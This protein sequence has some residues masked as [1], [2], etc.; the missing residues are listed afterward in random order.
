[1]PTAQFQSVS[2]IRRAVLREWSALSPQQR[3]SIR[4]FLLQF[5]VNNHAAYSPHSYCR[6]VSR[7]SCRVVC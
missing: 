7:V 3:D 1:M 2:T 4:D 6:V 5:L